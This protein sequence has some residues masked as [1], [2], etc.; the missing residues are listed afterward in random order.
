MPD[1][2]DVW[3]P[4][5]PGRWPF[6]GH[7]RGRWESGA[8][9]L[10]WA[11]RIAW[12]ALPEDAFEAAEAL[13]DVLSTVRGD[14][15]FTAIA[16]AWAAVDTLADKWKSR[17]DVSL[18]FAAVDPAGIVLSSTGLEAVWV[19]GHSGWV[20]AALSGSPLFT[21]PGAPERAPVPQPPL[22]PGLRFLGLPPGIAL[23]KPADMALACGVRP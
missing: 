8:I 2:I 16:S 10:A 4:G 6:A 22:R 5:S 21:E 11:G 17:G 12:C 9:R 14:G 15:R 19:E 3:M 23:P 13:R 18:L 1:A 7:V 20:A